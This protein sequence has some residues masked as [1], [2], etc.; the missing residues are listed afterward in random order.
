MNDQLSINKPILHEACPRKILWHDITFRSRI[1]GTKGTPSQ[2]NIRLVNGPGRVKSTTFGSGWATRAWNSFLRRKISFCFTLSTTFSAS[3]AFCCGCCCWWCFLSFL[4][5]AGFVIIE[6]LECFELD[7]GVRYHDFW[8]ILGFGLPVQAW[9]GWFTYR[10]WRIVSLVSPFCRGWC[11]TGG[12]LDGILAAVIP[13]R[14]DTMERS[15]GCSCIWLRREM[16]QLCS[17]HT[18]T[19]LSFYYQHTSTT[20]DMFEL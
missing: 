3:S 6:R 12:S 18:V 5:D 4:A 11:W 20:N 2:A 10:R 19:P 9:T 7:Q 13:Y 16:I 8:Y 1:S 14:Q 15:F 17:R